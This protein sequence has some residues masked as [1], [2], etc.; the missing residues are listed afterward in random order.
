[1]QQVAG[2]FGSMTE[3]GEVKPELFFAT[4][5]GTDSGPTLAHVTVSAISVSKSVRGRAC[6]D[7]ALFGQVGHALDPAIRR[8]LYAGN[9]ESVFLVNIDVCTHCGYATSLFFNHRSAL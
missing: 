1:M 8:K 9:R 2:R 5:G 6:G 3:G 7:A 4:G